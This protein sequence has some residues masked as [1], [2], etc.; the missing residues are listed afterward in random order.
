[1][2]M[3]P[4][5]LLDVARTC[6]IDAAEHAGNPPSSGSKT[7]LGIGE[8]KESS[9]KLRGNSYRNKGIYQLKCLFTLCDVFPI[10]EAEILR[11]RGP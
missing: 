4:A 11:L 9:Q 5:T 1:M 7:C 8:H 2:Q 3:V 6:F 10:T